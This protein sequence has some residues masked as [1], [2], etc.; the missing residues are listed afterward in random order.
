MS[1]FKD[2]FSSD[3]GLLS[4]AVILFM[5]GMGVFFVRYF[6]KHVREDSAGSGKP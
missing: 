6:V 2:L 3:V 4:A 1:A 5:L